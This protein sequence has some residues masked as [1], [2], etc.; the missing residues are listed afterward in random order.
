M[1]LTR[2]TKRHRK[3]VWADNRDNQ[4]VLRTIGNGAPFVGPGLD[5]GQNEGLST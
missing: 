3:H 5:I 4:N 1:K 2:Q